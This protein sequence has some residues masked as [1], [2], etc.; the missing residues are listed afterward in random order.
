M[1]TWRY[2]ELLARGL[3]PN[4]IRDR[5]RTGA[6]HRVTR[7]T[8]V[9]GGQP[10]FVD[11][12]HAVRQVLPPDTVFGFH[13]AARL[14][15]FGV[16]PTGRIHVISPTGR[17]VPQ[18]SGVVGHQAVLPLLPVEVAGL[19]CAAPERVIVDLARICSRIDALAVVDAALRARA[20]TPSALAGELALHDGL[21]GVRQA[22]EDRPGMRLRLAVRV[23]EVGDCAPVPNAA[24]DIWHCDAGGLYSG[25]ESASTGSGGPP[26]RGG[27]GP[28]DDEIY[29]RGAQVTNADGIVEFVTIYPGWYRGR[30]VHIHTKVHLDTSTTLTTQLYFDEAVSAQVYATGPYSSRTGRDTTNDRDGV[31]RSGGDT[32]PMLTLSRDG[33]GYLGLITIGV[34]R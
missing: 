16:V 15:G 10:S 22:R 26:G 12:L 9:S 20:S 27:T 19:P 30:T 14:Y 18:I 2:A 31:M 28:T 13:T 29:L 17:P 34:D 4:Q 6:L 23:Q 3:S 32:P 25:F 21:R 24:V 11:R 1:T 5:V 33:D 8:Y 7:G